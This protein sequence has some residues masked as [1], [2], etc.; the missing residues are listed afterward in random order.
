M[1]VVR[2]VVIQRSIL[3]RGHVLQKNCHRY[4]SDLEAGDWKISL[5]KLLRGWSMAIDQVAGGHLGG[6]WLE[7]KKSQQQF[8][9]HVPATV[10]AQKVI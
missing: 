2:E 9:Q 1:L 10:M 6:N 5:E 3:L 4:L 7:E 8:Q